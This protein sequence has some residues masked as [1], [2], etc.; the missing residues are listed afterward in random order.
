MVI[1]FIPSCIT[2]LES[3][4]IK[5]NTLM[6]ARDMFYQ[7]IAWCFIVAIAF[8]IVTWL[9][10]AW[11]TSKL[12][13][14]HNIATWK[15]FVP[16]YNVY[17]LFKLFW[18]TKHFWAFGVGMVVIPV[19]LA[20]RLGNPW[21]VIFAIIAI[22]W[23]FVMLVIFYI[24]MYK[25]AVYYKRSIWFALGLFFFNCIFMLILVYKYIDKELP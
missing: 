12:F 11:A 10:F 17:L 3:L 22:V 23:F 16:L 25:L 4:F 7:N 18:T 21:S 6:P 24:L 13:A 8:F 15:A 20:V 2:R 1:S 19:I 14:K 9:L 5:V